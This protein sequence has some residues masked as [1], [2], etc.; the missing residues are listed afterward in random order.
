MQSELCPSACLVELPSNPQ[1]GTC[2]RVG[3]L[4]K[5]LTNVLPRMLG[6]GWYPSS[7]MYSS[8]YFA[9]CYRE[10]GSQEWVTPCLTIGMRL[11]SFTLGYLEESQ[12]GSMPDS[13]EDEKERHLLPTA[14]AQSSSSSF[15]MGWG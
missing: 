2:S 1:F 15:S 13:P 8:L 11:C 3:K 6:I 5:S 12:A 7:Q 10:V 4:S 14:R 9:M